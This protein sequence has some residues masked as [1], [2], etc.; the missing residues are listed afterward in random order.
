MP[1]Q[2]TAPTVE[3][4]ARAFA[5]AAHLNPKC[6]APYWDDLDEADRD[7]YREQA[8]RVCAALNPQETP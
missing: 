4:W 6:D 8:R 2:P 3:Q 7:R 5:G 1:D